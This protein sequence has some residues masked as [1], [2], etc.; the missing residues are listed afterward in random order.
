MRYLTREQIISEAGKA[1]DAFAKKI[2][3]M[4]ETVFFAKPS[5]DKWSAAEHVKHLII[6]T[7]TTTLAYTLPVFIVRW[8]GGT[9]NRQSRTYEALVE[10]YKEKL[11]LGGK[12]SGRFV[13]KPM[14]IKH[15]QQ[16]LIADWNKASARFIN[17]LQRKTSEQKLD[18]YLARHPLLGRIT[19]R[20]LGYFTIYHTI[21][22]LDI[23]NQVSIAKPAVT[24]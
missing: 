19:L 12:A 13:P 10:R 17:A 14:N 6:S 15:G 1:F 3:E 18:N 24:K 2:A 16:Q 11:A 21:H 8:V 5:A 20:E 22:H 23:I 7:N 4:E 9:P